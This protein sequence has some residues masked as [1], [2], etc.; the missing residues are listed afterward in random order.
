LSSILKN[1]EDIV[2]ISYSF[3]KIRVHSENQLP[4]LLGSALKV[5][6]VGCGGRVVF[7]WGGFHLIMW[8]HQV[9][10][11]LKL[12]CGIGNITVKHCFDIKQYTICLVN[13]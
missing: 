12:G 6:V 4:G 13:C 1:I 7:W 2:H 3:V 11:W 5:S 10:L 8:P 9:C